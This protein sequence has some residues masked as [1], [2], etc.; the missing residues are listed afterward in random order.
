MD[1]F[2]YFF[3]IINHEYKLNYKKL[4]SLQNHICG[5]DRF[6][7]EKFTLVT[8]QTIDLHTYIRTYTRK[9]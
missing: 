4:D 9:Y 5:Y 7:A 1:T 3:C 2:Y 8:T 6:Q